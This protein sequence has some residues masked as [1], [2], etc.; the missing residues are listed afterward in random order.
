MLANGLG[1][2]AKGAEATARRPA[3]PPVKFS[4]GKLALGVCVNGLESLAKTHRAAKFSVLTTEIFTLLL[5]LLS[6]VPNVAA[7]APHRT[8]EIGSLAL[9]LA[10]HLI[11]CFAGQKAF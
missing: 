4:F 5:T 11:E 1:Q 6:E 3:T 10:A 9:K 7:Q 2:M 8:F